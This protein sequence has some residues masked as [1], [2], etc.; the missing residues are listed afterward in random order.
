M[1]CHGHQGYRE[2]DVRGGISVT[3]PYDEIAASL[4]KNRVQM[5]ALA[6]LILSCFVAV[7]YLGVWRLLSKLSSA[8]ALL[9][10]EQEKLRQLNAELDQKVDERSGELL[11]ANRQLRQEMSERVEAEREI[12]KLNAELEQRIGIRTGELEKQ[13]QELEKL[14]KLYVDREF[15][16]KELREQVARL[17][18][19]AGEGAQ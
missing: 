8:N 14:N 1:G 15:R 11:A 5:L 12:Q 2:G 6:A 13:N 9:A 7:F 10:E 18:S 4:E 19:K 17:Q 3:L 16:I